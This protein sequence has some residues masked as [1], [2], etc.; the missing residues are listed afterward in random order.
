MNKFLLTTAVAAVLALTACKGTNEKRGDEHLEKGQY[1][2]AINSYLNAKKAG[3]VSDEFYDNFATA[4]IRAAE[5]EAKKNVNSDMISGY[6]EKV[7]QIKDSIKNEEVI[8]DYARTVA[9]I[10]KSQATPEGTDFATMVNGFAAIDSA[11]SAAKRVGAEAE[12]KA[13]RLE[14]EKAVVAA[15]LSEAVG[16]EDPVVSEYMILKLAEVAPENADVKAALNKSRKG[17]RGYFLIFGENIGEKP[18]GRIDKWGYVM[19]MPT[20]KMSATGLS[21]ELQVWASTGNNTEWDANK[22]K[23]VSTDGQEVLAKAGSGWCEAEVVVG[24]KG[25]ERVEKKQQKNKGKGKLLNEFQCS[26]SISF[27]FA[28]GFVPDYIEYK[29]EYGI[30]R[31][32]LGQ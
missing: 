17:T 24:K 6:F 1:R 25:Q 29:D 32:F 9:T 19:A 11:M 27:T 4:L 12:I 14:A 28:K 5:T 7:N 31:K 8:K 2:N 21:G 3:S 18:S 16:E 22:L 23:L 26:A 10:G 13:I 20:I 30:G 15:N